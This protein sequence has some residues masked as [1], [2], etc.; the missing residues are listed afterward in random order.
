MAGRSVACVDRKVLPTHTHILKAE[1]SM[2]CGFAPRTHTN[3]LVLL[4]SSMCMHGCF[5]LFTSDN[6]CPA[7]AAPLSTCSDSSFGG[8]VCH[9]LSSVHR[10][11]VIT[12]AKARLFYRTSYEGGVMT[13]HCCFL[14]VAFLCFPSLPLFLSFFL[15]PQPLP[16]FAVFLSPSIWLTHSLFVCYLSLSHTIFTSNQATG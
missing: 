1:Y 8:M 13:A 7:Y 14:L 9:F 3:A 12:E 16:S 4:V 10:T 6:S 5:C 2:S 15:Q 11:S